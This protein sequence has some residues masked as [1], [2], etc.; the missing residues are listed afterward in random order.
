MGVVYE[1][2]DRELGRQVALK[3]LRQ[4]DAAAIYHLKQEFRALAD[5]RHP[6]LVRLHELV[7]SDGQ[8]FFSMELVE[9]VDLMQW[10]RRD[11]V[12]AP[13][14][15]ETIDA[16][17]E[18]LE[19]RACLPAAPPRRS[20]MRM[21]TS[22]DV[23][24]LRRTLRQL[25][26]GV[27]ALHAAGKLHRDVKPS[28]V[29]VT[30][31]GRVVLL[32]FGLATDLSRQGTHH[33]IDQH[34]LGTPEYMSPEQGALRPL[35]PASDWYSVGVVLFEA[36]TGG[37][38]F[39][40]SPLEILMAKERADGPSPGSLIDGV[41]EDL[42]ALCSA[43]LR[44]NPTARPTGEEILRRLTNADPSP[45]A[46]SITASTPPPA[47]TPLIGRDPELEALGRAFRRARQ[48]RAVA[49]HLHGHAGVGKTALL[50]R[51]IE[52]AVVTRQALVLQGACYERESVPYKALDGVIDSL[53]RHLRR[54][55]R[56]QVEALLPR[57]V[58]AI[59]RLFPVLGR[60][61]A[62]AAAP[63]LGVDAPDPGELRR[64]AFAA[65]RELFARIADRRPLILAIDDLQWGDLD[66]LALLSDLLRPP[67]PPPLL[68]V[69]SFRDEDEQNPTLRALREMHLADEHAGREQPL[70]PAIVDMRGSTTAR[71]K[72][73]AASCEVH[74]VVVEPL[75][76]LDA[77]TLARAV[78]D[79]APQR[80][81]LE[82]DVLAAEARGN[83]LLIV[84][85]VRWLREHPEVAAERLTLERVIETRVAKLGKRPREL[86]DVLAIAAR[87]I[88]TTV[89]ARAAGIDDERAA[90]VELRD[91]QL[92]R[93]ARV[94]D[95]DA[96]EVWHDRIRET[97][98]AKL[99]RAD[100]AERHLR[101]GNAIEASAA[102]DP[103]ALTHHFRAAGARWKASHYAALAARRADEA[104]AFDRAA[105]LFDLAIE[106]APPNAPELRSHRIMR[107]DAL[108]NAG[109]ARDAANE[110]LAAAAEGESDDA[111]DLHRRAAQCLLQSGHIDE[112][113][114]VFEGVLAIVGE[115]LPKSPRRALA[116]LMLRRA[117][118]RL[119][120]LTHVE[121]PVEAIPPMDLVR[122]DVFWA[123]AT[124]FGMV[125]VIVG[126]DF[127]TRHLLAA[128]RA[129]DT[130]RLVR[131][132]CAEAVFSATGG[133]PTLERTRLL[134]ARTRALANKCDRPH[135]HGLAETAD[136]FL[137]YQLGEWK[138]AREKFRRAERIFRER[139]SGV[140]WEIAN[141]RHFHLGALAHLGELRR[142]GER[143][144][145]LLEEAQSRGDLLSQTTVRVGQASILWLAHDDPDGGRR[146]LSDAIAHWSRRGFLLQ[147]FYDLSAQTQFD[148]YA[149]DLA[150]AW[151]RLTEA[152]PAL[153]ASML[154]RTQ[155]MRIEAWALRAR[156]AI[157]A[158]GLSGSSELRREAERSITRLEKEE[159]PWGV[160][161]AHATH[162][163]L[164][165]IGGD[166]QAA[167]KWLVKAA[168][169]FDA[170]G[171]RLH[172]EAAR[173]RVGA[174][175]GGAQGE[176]LVSSAD[177]WMTGEEIQDPARMTSMLLPGLG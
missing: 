55:T 53:T 87:P 38:P 125:D 132:F 127:A 174:L 68:L 150:A 176:A 117:Q 23:E 17:P 63:R 26:E 86:L 163:A 64:R 1:A 36:L 43:L 31:D 95:V 79:D 128:L 97:V 8:W 138:P 47:R 32:D 5:V 121:R 91:A 6:N 107:G 4:V 167:V 9:G 33:S 40:G 158:Y 155:R 67:Y 21:S 156:C 111:L 61:E 168:K 92:V 123:L 83:P 18:S 145:A 22:L 171:M 48:G 73:R 136:A 102:P 122:I 146:D 15:G 170:A 164:A 62:I 56:L 151:R 84:E 45:H 16:P 100:V 30:R 93:T 130:Y 25:V 177:V 112:G 39:V 13:M 114:K 58:H 74:E 115:R 98:V 52:E 57:D 137:H 7:S 129:G 70:V 160:S 50:R 51:F 88:E 154:L 29:V 147:H 75:S 166:D 140:A 106:L 65:L 142:L 14:S 37:L 105:K 89:A 169:G 19:E 90:V 175:V 157:A 101:L 12:P 161:F 116:S 113:L 133:A 78:M 141:V 77:R 162:A 10:V 103:E 3:T 172:S 152:W 153:Q 108:A 143:V 59:A 27:R 110:F 54:L 76:D 109:F 41:P 28:N 20:G 96:L 35:G 60:V 82:I 42:D 69:A 159:R 120:G 149:G 24:R 131:A 126:A 66:S 135:A 94:G 81:G 49:V 148:L 139:C 134:S 44:R 72:R 46:P 71:R 124:G 2:F 99:P 119:R 34:V 85:Y 11:D 144:P 165:H 118:L 173:R 80:P 104:L